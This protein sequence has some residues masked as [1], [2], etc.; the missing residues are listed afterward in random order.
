MGLKTLDFNKEVIIVVLSKQQIYDYAV[1]ILEQIGE[2]HAVRD[3]VYGGVERYDYSYVGYGLCI[4]KSDNLVK[5]NYEHNGTVYRGFGSGNVVEYVSGDWELLLKE[6]F[7]SIPDMLVRRKMNEG[8][9]ERKI[10]AWENIT[11]ELKEWVKFLPMKSSYNVALGNSGVV[12]S[13]YEDDI[14]KVMEENCSNSFSGT[15]IRICVY[16]F[17]YSEEKCWYGTKRKKES[18][19]VFDSR[20]NKILI[21]GTWSN[22]LA[23]VAERARTEKEII[24]K[25]S[26]PTIEDR[27]RQIRN[28]D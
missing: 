22:H 1:A 14:V 11:R 13:V 7:N 9:R 6:L 23:A 27:I 4:Y 15:N 26:Q 20:N 8:E 17:H 28:L 24:R 25:K 12:T 19:L 18:K 3:A 21:N 10:K 5:I 2:T 16:E